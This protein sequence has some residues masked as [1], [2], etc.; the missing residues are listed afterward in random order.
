[1]IRAAVGIPVLLAT[2]LAA[3]APACHGKGADAQTPGE[4][5]FT[6]PA[7]RII[8]PPGAVAVPVAPEPALIA[9]DPVTAS[10]DQV[11][12]P[13]VQGEAARR[14]AAWLSEPFRCKAILSVSGIPLFDAGS[15]SSTMNPDCRRF[16]QR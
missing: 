12:P 5:P 6:G 4:A 11:S 7:L 2:F 15:T 3:L 1:M 13:V 16:R 14:E 10:P 9:A 8:E